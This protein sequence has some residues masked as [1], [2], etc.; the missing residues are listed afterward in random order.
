MAIFRKSNLTM[1]DHETWS[2]WDFFIFM[3]VGGCKQDLLIQE[4]FPL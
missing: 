2:D 4:V 1:S 3:K